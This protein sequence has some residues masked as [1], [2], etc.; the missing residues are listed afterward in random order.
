MSGVAGQKGP[1]K[2]KSGRPS[3]GGEKSKRR[4]M[5]GGMLKTVGHAAPGQQCTQC[6]TQV[7]NSLL[8]ATP[9]VSKFHTCSEP[10]QLRDCPLHVN[11]VLLLHAP[12]LV[13]SGTV[14]AVTSSTPIHSVLCG[15]FPAVSFTP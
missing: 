6:G 15:V 14:S 3:K 11:T 2:R 9:P 5:V 10:S 7:C 4:R 8:P 1:L 13:Y 12:L